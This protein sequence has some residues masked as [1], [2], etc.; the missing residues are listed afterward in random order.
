MAGNVFIQDS[1]LE[2]DTP[3]KWYQN[4]NSSQALALLKQEKENQKTVRVDSSGYHSEIKVDSRES[5]PTPQFKSINSSVLR[6]LYSPT[7]T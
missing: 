5:S 6:F 2:V 4:Q 7:L 3:L 1:P